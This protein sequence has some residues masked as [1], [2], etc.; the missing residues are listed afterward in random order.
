[1]SA[2]FFRASVALLLFAAL[3]RADD[4][5]DAGW[6]LRDDRT[7]HPL[8]AGTPVSITNLVGDVRVREVPDPTLTIVAMIQQHRDDPRIAIVRKGA[9]LPCQVEALFPGAPPEGLY[10]PGRSAR[11]DLTVFVP[12]GSPV[13]IATAG[14]RLEAK[15]LTGDVTAR[16]DT[17]KI[18]VRTPGLI[19]AASRRGD[20]D[21]Q[22][23]QLGRG[24]VFRICS[25]AGKVS[26]R[27]PAAGA[28]TVRAATTGRIASDFSMAVVRPT[29]SAH[30]HATIQF[31]TS[32]LGRRL[33]GWALRRSRVE[34]ES[35]H[36]D[37][38]VL[39]HFPEL[40]DP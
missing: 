14:G 17:G 7:V 6:T 34:I 4:P 36:G 5:V 1:M 38:S 10:P 12:P 29:T 16:S 21:V 9:T 20:V 19:D 39:A 33:Y 22:I 23:R 8:K 28:A 37:V 32:A 26:V 24:R 40:E 25:E 3:A 35:E 2:A 18:L 31:G 30:K 27:L 11:V 15:G 13:S